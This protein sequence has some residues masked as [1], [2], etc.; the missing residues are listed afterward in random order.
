M[1][2]VLAALPLHQTLSADMAA[3]TAQIGALPPRGILSWSPH[4]VC[5]GNFI[6][7]DPFPRMVTILGRRKALTAIPP[8]LFLEAN[9][10]KQTLYITINTRRLSWHLP[11][12]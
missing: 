9:F 6:L 8:T 5:L 11:E 1:T 3:S 10:I 12:Q 4:G 2:G 7:T